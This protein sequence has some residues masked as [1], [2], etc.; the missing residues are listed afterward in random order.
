MKEPARPGSTPRPNQRFHDSTRGR[1]LA[2]LRTSPRTVDELAAELGLTD[3]GI[4]QHLMVLERDTM[5]RQAGVRRGPGAGKP[6][7]IYE[8]HPDAEP[9]LSRAYAPVLATLLEVLAD[10]LSSH[11][12]RKVLR[13]TGRRLAVRSGGRAPGDLSARARAAAEVLTSL[14]AAVEVEERRGTTR[15]RG[16]ACPLATATS[17]SP[18]VCRAVE[19]LV[20]EIT[21][22]KV[23]EC[24]ERSALPRCCFELT[25]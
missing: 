11:Q 24:C 1:L 7:A 12:T 17:R 21:G 20:A 2:L 14:G 5:V 13:E 23:H 10:E 8:L 4:R 25:A 16:S 6:A 15:L 19:S 22:A 18:H 3:N 9:L